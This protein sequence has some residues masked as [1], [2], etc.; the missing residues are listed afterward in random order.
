[1]IEAIGLVTTGFWLFMI[2]DCIRNEPERQIWLWIL[3]LVNVP[4][5]IIYFLTRWI[6]RGNIPLPNYF[7]RWTRKR[8]LWIAEAQAKNIGK[9]HQYVTLGNLLCDIGSFDKAEVAYKQ[10]LEKEA[11][12][13]QALWGAA[14]IAVKNH[15]FASAKE[16][17]QIILKIAPDYKYG[18]ASLIYG[19]TLFALKELD[20]AK[21]HL[22]QHIKNWSHPEAYITLAQ[23]LSQQSDTQAAR[24]YLETMI[25]K[26]RGSSYYHFKR[27]RHFIGKAEKLLKTLGR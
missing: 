1:M 12:N 16:H 11:D 7:T 21:I 26:I 22:E 20:T 3:L 27:N 15:K 2:Y 13:L 25:A 6:P 9:A 14:L 19:E 10:A 8:E 23:I 24:S 18:D 4:G 5:A 17:L